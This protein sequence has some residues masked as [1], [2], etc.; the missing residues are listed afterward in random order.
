[1]NSK[2]KYNIVF[3]VALVFIGLILE[4]LRIGSDE[5]L[6]FTSLGQWLIYIGFVGIAILIIRSLPRKERKVD[7]RMIFIANKANRITF[8]VIIMGSFLIMVWDGI[9]KI[10]ITYSLFMSYFVCGIIATYVITYK[11]LLKYF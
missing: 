8:L 11:V 5:F 7:E 1:M 4:S 3:S 10:T 9:S 2:L 6:G